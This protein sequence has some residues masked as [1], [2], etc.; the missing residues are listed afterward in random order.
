MAAWYD[1]FKVFNYIFTQGPLERDRDAQK[2]QG[3]AGITHPDVP[4]L[5]NVDSYSAGANSYIRVQNDMVDMTTTTN[6]TNRYKE[7]DRL[8][9]SVPEIEMAMTV[10]ADEACVAEDTIVETV[11]YGK[12]TIKWLQQN[13]PTE[14][15]AVYCY[16]FKKEEYTIGWAH[17]PRIVKKAKV[18]HILLDDGKVAKVTPDHRI[19]R[20]N[21]DWAHAEQLKLGDELMPFYRIPANQNLT[22]LKTNQFPRIWTHLKGWVHE[23]QF[24]DEWK[25]GKD[26][27]KYKKLNEF[28]R[29]VAAQ[30]KWRPLLKLAKTIRT[31]LNSKM[32]TEGWSPDEARLLGKK[33]DRRKI[34]GIQLYPETLVYDLSVDVYENFCTNSL[35]MHNCQKD[36]DNKTFKITCKKK[37]I[38]DELEYLFF[39]R[40]RLNLNQHNCWDKCK[41]LFI[42]GDEFLELVVN[43]DDPKNGVCALADLPP[44][45]MFR[46][47]SVKGKLIEFQQSKEGPDFQALQRAPITSATDSE[48][49][50]AT[51]IR[52][53]P[54]EIVHIRIGDYRKTFYPY[55][56]SLIEAARGPAHQLRMMEDAM[57][58]YRLCLIGN[59]RI[60]TSKGYKLLKDITKEDIVFS[61][62][63]GML[64][65]ANVLNLL[66]NGIKEVFRVRSKHVE[67]V[68]TKTHPILISRNGVVQYVEIQN[69]EPKQD[70]LILTKQIT[71]KKKKLNENS[72]EYVD[73]NLAE[74]LGFW[75]CNDKFEVGHPARELLPELNRIPDWLFESP[76]E[77]KKAFIK[78]LS[79][80]IGCE[81]IDEN[82]KWS[83]TI[84]TIEKSLIEDIKELWFSIGLC[85]GHIRE[86]SGVYSLD[87]SDCLLLETENIISVTPAGEER[88][89]DISVDNDIHNFIANGI[90]VHNSR[91]PERRVFYIDVGNLSSGR[92]EAFMDRMKDQFKKKKVSAGM[93]A[94]HG[95]SSVEERWHAPAQDEDYWV[96]IRPNSQTKIDTLPGAQNLGEVDDTVYFRNKLF[97]AL[98]FPKNYFSMEDPNATRI[99]LSAQDVKFARMIE[100]LQSKFEDALW[101]IAD[102]HLKMRG[103]PPE[104]YEDLII[105][106][107]PPSDWRE[108]SRAEVTS[109]RIN[110]AGSLQSSQ[111]MGTWDILI[112]ILKYSEDEANGIISRLKIQKLE[113]L[114]M[115]V[116]AQNPSL[117]GV[118]IPGQGETEMGAMPGGPNPMLGGEQMPQ[119]G[120]EQMPGME[121]PQP[122]PPQEPNAA[123]KEEAPQMLPQ[124]KQAKPIPEP[125]ETEIERYDLDIQDYMFDMDEEDVD[126][127]EME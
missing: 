94:Q 107:T 15:F 68:G 75:L 31:T 42:K 115:Q 114:K 44:E 29:L 88:V 118:G 71:N 109:N 76:T 70:K 26:L 39:H 36:E 100:R 119:P 2:G 48:L 58:V 3:G 78:G 108:L 110:Y 73:E 43:P 27:P 96:P 45:T 84:K 67:I 83:S 13:I 10:F 54:E 38:V 7:Y 49:A 122:P 22:K 20:R 104:C 55:G 21:G 57:V 105:K 18:L 19:L 127:S 86:E 17:S 47:E 98:N 121:P 90:P 28:T 85:S 113:D 95:A 80:A 1:F 111:L 81:Q 30:M 117:L 14:R 79:E 69:L 51:A 9:A 124:K 93:G 112:K 91:A 56:V 101:E 60:R 77:I 102:R 35:V 116:L 126:W 72:Y 62:E 64:Y 97:T 5:R 63:D 82:G 8:V 106:M 33:Q 120:M 46:I 66:D 65:S 16:D 40:D 99:T 123:Q 6:R 89:Y 50:Q 61:Y 103:F 59:T 25:L 24:I 125:S 53:A 37:D 23:R 4:D 52:F 92:L 41:R 32:K 11:F 74:F 34:I 87:I 12:K